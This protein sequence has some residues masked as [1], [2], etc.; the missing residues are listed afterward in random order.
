M[1]D[2]LML[3]HLHNLSDERVVEFWSLS[4]YA[5]FFCGFAC[6]GIHFLGESRRSFLDA[7]HDRRH[8]KFRGS[9]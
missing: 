5:Q 9:D 7:R 1:V 6:G 3:K 8:H 2:L 4:P